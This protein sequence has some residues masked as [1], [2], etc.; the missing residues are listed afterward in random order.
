MRQVFPPLASE[1]SSDV[2]HL[3]QTTLGGS[4]AIPIE[5]HSP[6]TP[7]I[8]GCSPSTLRVQVSNIEGIA[9]EWNEKRPGAVKVFLEQ[10][11]EI[12]TAFIKDPFGNVMAL[13]QR[14]HSVSRSRSRPAMYDGWTVAKDLKMRRMDRP[15]TRLPD[16]CT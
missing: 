3:Y 5:D 11:Y 6:D 15:G 13:P 1:V 2:R 4:R 14:L 7:I 9:D 10:P 8:L 12:P 16:L